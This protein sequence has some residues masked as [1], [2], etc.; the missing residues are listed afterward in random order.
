MSV[1]NNESASPKHTGLA[2]LI[3]MVLVFLY[4]MIYIL[5]TNIHGDG[6]FHTLYAREIVETGEL[7]EHQP[8]EIMCIEDGE[9]VMM[10]ISYPLTSHILIGLFYMLGEETAVK[11]FSPILAMLTAVF[12]YLLLSPLSKPGAFVAAILAILLNNERFVMVPLMEQLLLFG[13]VAS[14]YFYY[15]WLNGQQKKYAILTGLFLGLVL[16]TKQQGLIFVGILLL[17]AFLAGV[18]RGERSRKTTI[19]KQLV[20]VTV[21]A[22]IIGAGP[23]LDQIDRNGT[24]E[25]IPANS[26]LPFLESHY[27][28]DKEATQ[29][30]EN[31][32]EYRP[33]YTSLG[34]TVATYAL[35]PGLYSKS[36][37]VVQFLTDELFLLPLLLLLL[38]IPSLVYLSGIS[39]LF[40]KDKLLL[41]ILLMLLAAEVCITYLTDTHPYQY[42]NIAV[43]IVGILLVFG[44]LRIKNIWKSI[45]SKR[46][47]RQSITAVIV[48][49]ILIGYVAFVGIHSWG[50]SGRYDDYHVRAYQ[51][52]GD[53]VQD[54]TPEDAIFLAGG[55]TGTAFTYYSNRTI[56]WL[57][58]GGG[59]KV[60]LIFRSSD[61]DEA[62]YWLEHYEIDYIFIDHRQ[63]T[64]EGVTDH[65]PEDG[66]PMYIDSYPEH[67]TRT[68]SVYSDDQILALYEVI[69]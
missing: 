12:I 32:I 42:H 11:L 26:G 22:I 40:H 36:I 65:I 58:E 8:Y 61:K 2:P 56:F 14:I 20:L 51:E 48:L 23:V 13:M 34:E 57:S 64:R 45:T 49:G 53:F 27:P 38:A 4:L 69:S 43:A 5:P 55:G 25:A 7:L 24:F 31:I 33:G 15:R 6:R 35:I 21:L 16:A 10:P 41:A 66:L 19:L 50:D 63:L 28:L 37:R 59:A 60:P 46:I 17:L 67:F 39:Y 54:N 44:L 29:E 18:F 3:L 47:V 9:K 1:Q 68:H 30:L 62:L 52:M